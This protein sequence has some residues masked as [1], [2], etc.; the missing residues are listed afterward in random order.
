M[1][2]NSTPVSTDPNQPPQGVLFQGKYYKTLDE[3]NEAMTSAGFVINKTAP[4]NAPTVKPYD[5]VNDDRSLEQRRLDYR[6]TL[7]A[8]KRWAA[9]DAEDM[10]SPTQ[11]GNVWIPG[12]TPIIKIDR[13]NMFSR[14][15][16][17]GTGGTFR[18]ELSPTNN[19]Q[20]IANIGKDVGAL[21]RTPFQYFKKYVGSPIAEKSSQVADRFAPEWS[22]NVVGSL[23]DAVE[24]T[25][26]LGYDNLV[27][28]TLRGSFAT[29]ALPIEILENATMFFIG[30]PLLWAL[31]PSEYEQAQAS[32]MERIGAIGGNTTFWQ[33]GLESWKGRGQYAG[34]GEGLFVQGPALEAKNRLEEEVRPTIYGQT[35]TVGRTLWS[36]L[37]ETGVIQAG[38]DIHS[39]LTGLTDGAFQ[40]YADPLTWVKF[41]NYFKGLGVIADLPTSPATARQLEKLAK[42]GVVVD[43]DLWKDAKKAKEFLS[44]SDDLTDDV[45][46]LL[47]P[48]P[49]IV[50]S[51]DRFSPDVVRTNFYD[52]DNPLAPRNHE[53]LLDH[54]LYVSDAPYVATSYNPESALIKA[55]EL[56]QN[57][58]EATERGISA[59]PITSAK[60]GAAR[61]YKF[62]FTPEMNILDGEL[63]LEELGVIANTGERAPWAFANLI[64]DYGMTEEF[65]R[66]FYTKLAE[67][68]IPI[69]A[70]D[71]EE[72]MDIVRPIIRDGV[73]SV[74]SNYTLV[75]LIQKFAGPTEVE[76][77]VFAKAT[78]GDFSSPI[79]NFTEKLFFSNSSTSRALRNKARFEALNA[80]EKDFED[81]L[82]L[83]PDKYLSVAENTAGAFLQDLIGSPGSTNKLLAVKQGDEFVVLNNR[84]QFDFGIDFQSLEFRQGIEVFGQ[85]Q[86]GAFLYDP[87]T[88]ARRVD[89]FNEVVRVTGY[90]NGEQWKEGFFVRRP[91][92]E[93]IRVY[94][95]SF[96]SSNSDDFLKRLFGTTEKGINPYPDYKVFTSLFADALSRYNPVG[97]KSLA[98][99]KPIELLNIS[100]R[101]GDY[102]NFTGIR[103]MMDNDDIFFDFDHLKNIGPRRDKIIINDWLAA[104]GVDAVRYDGGARIGSYG[105]HN[106]FA[107]FKPSK[108]R[109]LDNLT[110]ERIPTNDAIN[111]LDE[112]D[113]IKNH[114]EDLAKARGF[115]N[116]AGMI[117]D[118]SKVAADANQ[119]EVFKVSGRWRN[120]S[121]IL[122]AED[123]PYRIWSTVLKRRSP[124]LAT[125]IA[126]AKT[127]DEVTRLMDIAV[128]NPDPLN[129]MR[130]LPGWSGNVVSEAGYRIKQQVSKRSALLATL[131]RTP[132]VPIDDLDAGARH[133]DDLMQILR[134][135]PATRTD[136]MNKFLRIASNRD[137][138]VRNEQLFVFARDWEKAIIQKRLEPLIKR[139]TREPKVSQ[140]GGVVGAVSRAA[141][142]LVDP[143]AG[144]DLQQFVN[145]ASSYRRDVLDQTRVWVG[146][147][148]MEGVPLAHIDGNGQ[149]PLLMSELFNS[150]LW[151]VD[152]DDYDELI[153]LFKPWSE[154]MYGLRRYKGIYNLGE[155]KDFMRTKAI[156]FQTHQWKPAVLFGGKYT[157]RVVADEAMRTN[158]SG[159]FHGPFSYLSEIFSGRLNK[160]TLGRVFPYANEA[161]DINAELTTL[162]SARKSL[163]NAQAAGDT[164]TIS[165]LQKVIDGID[166]NALLSRRDEIEVLLNDEAVNVLDAMIGRKPGAAFETAIRPDTP[167]Y[168]RSKIQKIVDRTQNQYE[169]KRAIADEIAGLATE[170]DVRKV[171]E[172]LLVGTDN[173]LDSVAR[174]LYS[175]KGREYFEKYYQGVVKRPGYNWD[176]LA[177]ARRR[178]DALKEAILRPT[179]GNR[180]V[181]ELISSRAINGTP[182]DMGG[183]TSEGPLSSKALRDFLTNGK[184]GSALTPLYD[185]TNAPQKAAYFPPMSAAEIEQKSKLFRWWMRNTYGRA[186]DK[187]AR[188]PLFNALKW[189]RVVDMMPLISKGEVSQLAT[190]V[191]NSDL[192]RYIKANIAANIDRAGVGDMTLKQVE[193]FAAKMALEESV[194]LLFDASKKSLFG[195][196]HSF[197]FPFFD[198]WRETGASVLKL[199]VNPNNLHKVDRSRRALES[200]RVGGPGESVLFGPGDADNDGRM[201]GMLYTD[202]NTGK[203]VIATPL[204]GSLASMMADVPFN[205]A[206]PVEGL[207]LQTNVI[208]GVGPVVAISY[209]AF[210]P[211]SQDW[212][213]LNQLILPFGSPGERDI[214]DYIIP[215]W[216]KR[217]TQGLITDKQVGD[218]VSGLL[219][220]PRENEIFKYSHARAM[221][222]YAATRQYQPGEAGVA[223]LTKDSLD[224]ALVLWGMRGLAQFFLP[225]APIT[226]YFAETDKGLM[227]LGKLL[228]EMRQTERATVAAGGTVVDAQE[229][230]IN[231]YGDFIIPYFASLSKG[232]TPGSEPS[233]EFEKFRENNRELFKKYPSVAALFF[234]KT[235]NYD[236]EVYDM[237]RRLGEREYL[238][239][240]ELAR[241]IDSLFGGIKYRRYERNLPLEYRNTPLGRAILSMK[242]NEIRNENPFWN[243]RAYAAEQS[244][245]IRMR[246]NELISSLSNPAVQNLDAY[247]PL[248]E[249]LG[250]REQI[251]KEIRSNNPKMTADGWK[252]NMGGALEREVLARQGER[253]KAG[254]PAFANLWDNLLSREF[255]RL[256]SDTLEAMYRR[257]GTQQEVTVPSGG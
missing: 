63:T 6:A 143:R 61:V 198:A 13:V 74:E 82:R 151:L 114:A 70:N 209:D 217:I 14:Y 115:H 90:K 248:Q 170:P 220:D 219:G 86:G 178:V 225:A 96:D 242:A 40:L 214:T 129:Y 253:I 212:R 68:G 160:D 85:G 131:P 81:L 161:S 110:G 243:P 55:E 252:N 111:L 183:R 215:L 98:R 116:A 41:A 149:G 124:E 251:I 89:A 175:G 60:E 186:S 83:A 103:M 101:I 106:A 199:A 192:P 121:N 5:P 109:M 76:A 157:V 218:A 202:P 159:A 19:A 139:L 210:G 154:V 56:P 164:K 64:E 255:E 125:K 244:A 27:K 24:W 182:F 257:T 135:D 100:E 117:E 105:F 155:I 31:N 172:A 148:L 95:P 57:I 184:E 39:L 201:E 37:V 235:G 130:Q 156:D 104:R 191:E 65:H 162:A 158:M 75:D 49:G 169:W 177:E 234:E 190:F 118:A 72:M 59:V 231:K 73:E 52:I 197:L 93:P 166:E 180:D 179:G 92:Q 79:S 34:G 12:E 53:N 36:P 123:E 224:A 239:P 138:T 203:K 134:V 33:Y 84:N 223:Q 71:I 30:D 206:I 11:R 228:D 99:M 216:A 205:F 245:E 77:S 229:A 112:A 240:D 128:Y 230:M 163:A 113:R 165:R 249:Y 26:Q 137:E 38:D 80:A 136:Q 176:N 213:W 196:Q 181:I 132:F 247:A 8:Y 221:Q 20:L 1:A 17:A 194:D 145:R 69:D 232:T 78:S 147:D 15:S 168:M 233:L 16:G 29:L 25:A 226:Q 119:W 246:M 51:G 241:E 200:F 21:V 142:K 189:N 18:V 48:K 88:T 91:G 62:E 153:K 4:A 222:S 146:N 237:Q 42:A 94:V 207:S 195:R 108:M 254:N 7:D 140:K 167:G 187:F 47:N 193:D 256:D 35:A 22:E 127:A 10:Q 173:A 28:P 23:V 126:E 188:I 9:Q 97:L 58:A 133:L 2:T 50:Y 122:A 32:W 46:D 150:N 204:I 208:P 66:G 171:A 211:Q 43:P 44:L 144:E 152:P 236:L 238:P 102:G 45:I 54:G 227:P 87:E 67:A 3:L 120:T 185:D 174:W 107:V 250:W 141:A